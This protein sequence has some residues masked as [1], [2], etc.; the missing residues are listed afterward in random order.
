MSAPLGPDALAAL[1]RLDTPTVCNA[2]ELILPERRARGFNR[3]PLVAPIP[4]MK[5]VVGYARTVMIRSREPHPRSK[6]EARTKRLRYYEDIARTPLPS[7]C[8]MQDVDGADAGF[9]CFWG[10]VQSNLHKALGCAGVV[11]D[12]AVRDIDAWAEGFFVLAGAVMPSH[13]HVDIVDFG[14]T[15]S[16]AGMIVS[17]DD[18]VHA[19]RHGAVVIPREAAPKVAEAADLLTRREKVVLDACRAPGFRAADLASIFARMDEIH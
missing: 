16:V 7:L 13:A 12:G 18:I 6:D 8:V 2:L 9:G 4:T 5:P 1:A 10:E 11:T 17:P 3:K 15:V 14:I 19:D